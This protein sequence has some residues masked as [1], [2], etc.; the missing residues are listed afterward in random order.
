MQ[1][2]QFEQQYNVVSTELM[3]PFA[4]L[5]SYSLSKV[6]SFLK[7][8]KTHFDGLFNKIDTSHQNG[9][10]ARSSLVD[11][12]IARKEVQYTDIQPIRVYV[13]IYL[14]PKATMLECALALEE[15]LDLCTEAVKSTLNEL[16]LIINGYIGAPSR[17][18]DSNL[19]HIE[20]ESHLSIQAIR[21]KLL[22]RQK[23]NQKIMTSTGSSS[24]RTFSE[25]YKRINDHV[26]T[27]NIAVKINNH[28]ADLIRG[29]PALLKEYEEVTQDVQRLNKIIQDSQHNESNS[30]AVKYIVDVVYQTASIME[31][32]GATLYNSQIFL[33]AVT[34]T[35]RILENSMK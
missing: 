3:N 28:Y 17:L 10:L 31:F 5:G 4:K 8:S 2:D 26:Q 6:D 20:T 23:E 7:A 9:L 33:K 15:D 32:L 30:M 22:D 34:D 14:K 27:V 11:Q 12:K 29:M 35:I 19:I 1:I 24:F 25:A 16:S 18:A 13:P 21:A